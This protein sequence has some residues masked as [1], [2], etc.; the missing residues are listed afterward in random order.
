[1]VVGK[2]QVFG[3][4]NSQTGN[5]RYGDLAF[6]SYDK[7]KMTYNKEMYHSLR[8]KNGIPLETQGTEFGKH[9]KYYP[10]ER[11]GFIHAYKNQGL[12]PSAGKGLMSNISFYQMQS[13]NSN[14]SQYYSA[15]WWHLCIKLK[16]MVKIVALFC[17]LSTNFLTNA[18][19]D[20]IKCE[21]HLLILILY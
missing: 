17:V 14:P 20:T 19:V 1:M 2:A 13:F 8:V 18:Q 12:Y 16:K 11:L 4:T 15:K 9:L 5:I 6:D 21:S 3:S 10:E 7:L